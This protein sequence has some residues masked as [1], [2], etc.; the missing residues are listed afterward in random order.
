MICKNHLA[1]SNKRLSLLTDKVNKCKSKT[2]HSKLRKNKFN[3][4]WPLYKSTLRRR[5]SKKMTKLKSKN[6]N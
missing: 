5:L 1:K 2:K 4:K 3:K 6:N